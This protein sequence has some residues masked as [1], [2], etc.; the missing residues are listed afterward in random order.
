M[1]KIF[2]VL[3]LL[4]M[5]VTCAAESTIPVIYKTITPGRIFDEEEATA[6][7]RLVWTSDFFSQDSEQGGWGAFDDG[8][9]NFHVYGRYSEG[10]LNE[11]NG[12][13]MIISRYT[14]LPVEG[15]NGLAFVESESALS[16]NEDELAGTPAAEDEA[17]FLAAF[18]KAL[19]PSAQKIAVAHQYTCYYMEEA[20]PA[21]TVSFDETINEKLVVIVQKAPVMRVVCFHF[22][23][24]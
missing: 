11:E 14:G 1:K 10:V 12:L 13:F 4:A 21:Y 15:Q 8:E 24:G 22:T 20:F 23:A 3:L 19:V 9:G 16:E 5:T 6:Y 2:A 17:Q 18:A 7:A